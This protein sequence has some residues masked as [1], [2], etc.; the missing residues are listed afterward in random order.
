MINGRGAMGVKALDGLQP[1]GLALL[2]L[3]LGPGDGLPVWREDESRARIGD[4]DAVAG[5]LVDI[6]EEGLLDGVLVRAGLDEHAVLQEDV[7]GLEHMLA[8]VNG[9]G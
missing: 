3:I 5:R 8:L 9:I 1:P 4:L 7:G 6:K 2:A